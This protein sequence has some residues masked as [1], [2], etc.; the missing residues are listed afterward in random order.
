MDIR[1]I[2]VYD[3]NVQVERKLREGNG[4]S[5]YIQSDEIKLLFD[6]GWKGKHLVNNMKILGISPN[7]IQKIFF[8]HGHMD[9]TH[10][11]KE[12]LKSRETDK[13][14]EILGHPA[15]LESKSFK[16]KALRIFEFRY[17]SRWAGFPKIHPNSRIHSN[18]S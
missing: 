18:I 16:M 17:P 2:N 6:A 11:L 7:Y 5:F 3:N 9:H 12:L 4:E 14:L 1:V 15:I 13:I 8:S 10:G